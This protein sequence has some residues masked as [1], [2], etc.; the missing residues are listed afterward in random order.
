VM[1]LKSAVSTLTEQRDYLD[2]NCRV[3]RT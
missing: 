3:G 1:Y 2:R